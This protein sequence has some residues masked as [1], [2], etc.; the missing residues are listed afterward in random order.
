M[1]VGVRD[2]TMPPAVPLSVAGDGDERPVMVGI[3]SFGAAGAAEL[4]RLGRALGG[5]V[6]VLALPGFEARA[7]LPETRD[8]LFDRL[9]ASALDAADGRPLVLLGRSSGGLLAHAV[10]DRLE[11]RGTP[12]RGLVLLDTYEADLGDIQHEWLAALMATGLGRLRGRV[13]DAAEETALLAA[14]AYLRLMRGWRAGPLATPSLLV[15]AAEPVGGMPAGAWRAT[16]SVPH[17]RV[18]APGDHFTMLDD[19][20]EAVAGVIR[21]WR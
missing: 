3:P 13:S 9:A 5:A 18:E 7:Q 19:H 6:S 10:A 21:A 4:L 8:V 11:Q 2:D 12:P 17:D 15:A 14:G 20:A 16:R 1:P